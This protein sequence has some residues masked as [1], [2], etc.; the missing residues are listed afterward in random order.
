MLELRH[1]LRRM[2]RAPAFTALAAGT[3]ALGIAA[4]TAIF[5]LADAVVL[6]PL[7]YHDP[8]RRVM[9][10]NRWRGFDK[11]W[12]NPAEMRAYHER[13]PS[14]AA[15]THWTLDSRNLT[16]DGDAV[17]VSVGFVTANGFDVLGARPLLGRGF[18]E[19]EDRPEGP[20]V[21]VL[22]HA[23]WQGRFGG[24]PSAV[25]RQIQLDGCHR[26]RRARRAESSFRFGGE[27]HGNI[28]ASREHHEA[29]QAQALRLES[30]PQT[31][32]S[33]RI[34]GPVLPACTGSD[35]TMRVRLQGVRSRTGGRGFTGCRAWSASPA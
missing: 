30:D 5:S 9:V 23:L 33:P 29:E 35:S 4:S 26:A 15:V 2:L 22:G 28:A 18:T 27:R 14:L 19:D 34:G 3:L 20:R 16:G 11:T 10:W 17:R 1:A 31:H 25:G 21:A 13:C 8:A 32:T 6:A 24:D 7:P 12:V